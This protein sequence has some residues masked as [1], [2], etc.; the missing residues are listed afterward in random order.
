MGE[1]GLKKYILDTNVFNQVLDGEI[2][3]KRFQGNKLFATHVQFDELQETP[4]SVRREK[5]VSVFT[6]IGPKQ[7]PTESAV[8]GVSKWGEVKWSDGVKFF[9]T[10]LAR[11][12]ELDI[13]SKKT[14]KPKNQS[15]DILIAVT[16]IKQ[17]LVLITNDKNLTIVTQE[18]GGQVE[19]FRDAQ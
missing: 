2:D 17:K 12:K 5:L 18:F 6:W 14:K 16:A 3:V 7:I 1:N 11:L 19:D 15:R 10:I 8:W 4:D 9:E 13:R